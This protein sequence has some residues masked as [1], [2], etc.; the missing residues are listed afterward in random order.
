MGGAV[1]TLFC[2]GVA[3]GYAGE[4]IL[5]GAPFHHFDI[6]LRALAGDNAVDNVKS[7]ELFQDIGFSPEAATAI[8][9]HSDLIDSYLYSP[10]WWAKGFHDDGGLAEKDNRLKAS[11]AQYHHL[12]K[13]HFDD[14]FTTEAVEDTWTRYGAGTLA[15]LD[16]AAAQGDDGV[17]AAYN[18]LGVS[19]HAVQDFYS[20]SSWINN[21][22]N[23]TK[24]WQCSDPA[25][26]R[27]ELYTGA[28]QSLERSAQ[29]HHG[30][31]SLECS[32]FRTN[33]F[34][35]MNDL[36]GLICNGLSP[37]ND[38]TFCISYRQCPS[39]GT[40]ADVET[41]IG[42]IPNGIVLDPAGIALDSSH[43]AK[44][45]GIERGLLDKNTER[46][47]P[48]MSTSFVSLNQCNMIANFGVACNQDA[49]SKQICARNPTK[50]CTTDAERIFATSKLLATESTAQ[51]V[52]SID[53]YMSARHADFW[54][55]VRKGSDGQGNSFVGLTDRTKQFEDFSQLPFQFLSVGPYPVGANGY[56]KTADGWYLRLRLKTA[57]T[58]GA[59]TDADIIASVRS[60]SGVQDFPLD[61][62]PIG[63]GSA[64]SLTLT[65]V[66][67]DTVLG[68]ALAY[69]DFER[70]DNDVYTI[71]P[72]TSMPT[73]ITLKNE[74][75]TAGE[76]TETFIRELGQGII[77][78][79][80]PTKL[81]I[82]F[83]SK[84]DVVG[85]DVQTLKVSELSGASNKLITLIGD[86][87]SE[88]KY[89]L[90][91]WVTDIGSRGLDSG[92]SDSGFKR[93]EIRPVHLE[94]IE[95]SDVDGAFSA[96]DEPF[97]FS[98]LTAFNGYLTQSST[99]GQVTPIDGSSFVYQTMVYQHGM[100]S[101]DKMPLLSTKGPWP[102]LTATLGP[103]GALVLA[104][105]FFESDEE[106]EQDRQRRFNS[107]VTGIE[108]VEPAPFSA[109]V[110]AIGSSA[111]SEWN[112]KEID[113]FGFYR[114]DSVKTIQMFQSNSGWTI[115]GNSEQS[116]RLTTSGI[117][118][119]GRVDDIFRWTG[120]AL[121]RLP[122][123]P[124]LCGGNADIEKSVYL[125]MPVSDQP[126]EL[127]YDG[128]SAAKIGAGPGRSSSFLAVLTKNT[129]RF[130]VKLVV[131][132]TG[133][134]YLRMSAKGQH[135][136]LSYTSLGSKA[137]GAAKDGLLTNERKFAVWT[138]TLGQQPVMRKGTGSDTR[139]ETTIDGKPYEISWTSVLPI[140]YGRKAVVWNPSIGRMNVDVVDAK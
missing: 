140:T 118:T 84:A 85:S 126:W 17:S 103:N 82:T 19:V 123:S 120:K 26:R 101:G 69:N 80:D 135:Y 59:G 116:F 31:I 124:G 134:S 16:W 15:A 49:T 56:E 50:T 130:P 46:F 102:M 128:A 112:L 83:G 133:Q 70:G 87:K 4:D 136:E 107:F 8:A 58:Q 114:G 57:D 108:E 125:R 14:L 3:F 97:A 115:A 23:R 81:A 1:G 100:D 106:T 105:A 67:S 72:I 62:M 131:D 22:P 47:L 2:A 71:G 5:N 32:V 113:V 33:E 7:G 29:H 12:E 138:T 20:H 40:N 96:Q 43:L 38:S 137:L 34:K 51:W 119:M 48:G 44:P 53:I 60:A 68:R 64:T 10:I 121:S 98:S 9:W 13:L 99:L 95:E 86:G 25:Q 122:D 93:F 24:T 73:S 117:K 52:K 78:T 92:L 41:P 39:G 27:T 109:S 111:G 94:V 129:A 74:A 37:F 42:T 110:T 55:K 61:Y 21:E 79:F 6:S 54:A 132:H 36:A 91:F 75:P 63:S 65:S 11:L 90:S 28:Y 89:S 139:F 88:G 66:Q 18:I 127:S 77:D 30:K 76:A 35:E 45:G 104:G